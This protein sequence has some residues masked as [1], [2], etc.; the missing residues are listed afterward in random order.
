MSLAEAYRIPTFTQPRMDRGGLNELAAEFVEV[1]E[2]NIQTNPGAW[3]QWYRAQSSAYNKA[4]HRLISESNAARRHGNPQR[5]AQ[6][7]NQAKRIARSKI[8]IDVKYK[9][10][11]RRGSGRRRR[12]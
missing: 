7:R 11:R 4:F 3:V 1:G 2:P 5:A 9:R 8:R 10:M 6:L 12:F